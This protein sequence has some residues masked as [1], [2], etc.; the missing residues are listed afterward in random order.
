MWRSAYRCS[1]SISRI[2][3]YRP[4]IAPSWCQ[5]PT[6][7]TYAAALAKLID[8]PER[9]MNMARKGVFQGLATCWI[10]VPNGWRT[11]RCSSSWRVHQRESEASYGS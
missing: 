8:H 2:V 5:R 6:V 1:P 4:E 11:D 10:G 7:Q 3:G 9:R